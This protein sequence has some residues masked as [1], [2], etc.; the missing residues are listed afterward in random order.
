MLLY[1]YFFEFVLM[2]VLEMKNLL[3]TSL[4]DLVALRNQLKKE[5]F[6]MRVKL[7]LRSLTQTHLMRLARKNIARINTAIHQLVNA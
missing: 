1:I 5:S 7:S 6:D 2:K 3:A 4:K